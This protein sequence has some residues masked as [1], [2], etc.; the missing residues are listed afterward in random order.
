MGR[1]RDYSDLWLST[2]SY[3]SVNSPLTEAWTHPPMS[4]FPPPW[5]HS[6]HCRD[7]ARQQWVWALPDHL[8]PS[9]ETQV[10]ITWIVSAIKTHPTAEQREDESPQQEGRA[11]AIQRSLA[12]ALPR[13]CARLSIT[14]LT[15][16]WQHHNSLWQCQAVPS[17]LPRNSSQ[18]F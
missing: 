5:T 14:A 8:H 16:S 6:C 2:F 17:L 10:A 9:T 11:V 7:T 15:G 12:G 1:G 3:W 4:T 13:G 18:G